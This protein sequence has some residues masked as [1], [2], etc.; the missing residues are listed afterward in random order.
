MN[1]S[2]LL[3]LGA[4]TACMPT[5]DPPAEPN[6]DFEVED[7]A[8]HPRGLEEPFLCRSD[9]G[10]PVACDQLERPVNSQLSCDAAGCHGGFT[11][12]GDYTNPDRHL[13]GS[14]GPSCWTCHDQEW[15]NRVAP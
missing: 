14:D 12:D 7:G 9:S 3:L 5:F 13:H 2:P 4:L 11:F 10:A 15:S 8:R 1:R 6:H